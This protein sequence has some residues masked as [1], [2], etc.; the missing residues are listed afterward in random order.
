MSSTTD[1]SKPK[2][3]QLQA[4]SKKVFSVGDNEPPYPTFT[5]VIE[6]SGAGVDVFMD[7]GSVAPEAIQAAIKTAEESERSPE[8]HPI[9]NVHIIHRF[10]M[11]LQ[12][13]MQMHQRLS[14]LIAMTTAQLQASVKQIEEVASSRTK[15]DG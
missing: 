4:A 6:F 12:T 9:V 10:A 13:A 2:L 8:N 11:T 5:N 14:E 7:I 1:T 15:Q 3:Q